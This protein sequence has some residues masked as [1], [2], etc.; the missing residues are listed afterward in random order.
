MERKLDGL[1][2]AALLG[3]VSNGPGTRRSVSLPL[4]KES[5]FLDFPS[6][7]KRLVLTQFPSIPPQA[8]CR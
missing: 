7:W 2:V 6:G 8:Q 5:N 1:P 3:S 4:R